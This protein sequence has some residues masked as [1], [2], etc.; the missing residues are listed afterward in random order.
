MLKLNLGG[1][2]LFD[3]GEGSEELKGYTNVDIRPGKGVDVVY[4]L[5]KAKLPFADETFQEI[6]AS[7]VI[8]HLYPDKVSAVLKD[9]TR[10]L[11]VGGLLRI[12]CPNAGKIMMDY[13]KS[14]IT[15]EEASIK[16]FGNQ[17]YKENLH[18]IAFDKKRLIAL[19]ESTAGLKCVSTDP[20]PNLNYR[21]DL[22]IQAVKQQGPR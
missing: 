7:H 11:K 22:G 13:C 10:V 5:S 18:R 20:R 15:M 12:Y 9:W 19:I 8:E 3:G 16:L 1:T 21:Y 14:I 4:D 6:R 2:E 17:D